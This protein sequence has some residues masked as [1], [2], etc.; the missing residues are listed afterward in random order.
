MDKKEWEKL[1]HINKEASEINK[2][3]KAVTKKYKENLREYKKADPN[4]RAVL[5]QEFNELSKESSNLA[6]RLLDNWEKTGK[7]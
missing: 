1:K 4:R 6:K 2:A 7:E 5:Q 3:M